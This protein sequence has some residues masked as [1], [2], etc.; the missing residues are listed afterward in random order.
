MIKALER[1]WQMF[2]RH[3]GRGKLYKKDLGISKSVA[4]EFLK[5]L[6]K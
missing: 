3:G 1:K 6:N 5:L 4:I 2:G